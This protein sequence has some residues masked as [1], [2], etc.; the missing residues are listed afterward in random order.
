[1]ARYPAI[2]ES[3]RGGRV[4]PNDPTRGRRAN[5]TAAPGFRGQDLITQPDAVK[6]AADVAD[7]EVVA[8][9]VKKAEVDAL[10]TP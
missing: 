5:R 4:S 3:R 9:V 2:A 6:V 8:A 1:M 7:A 10:C